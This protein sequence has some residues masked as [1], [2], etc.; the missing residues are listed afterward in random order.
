[1]ASCSEDQNCYNIVINII[2]QPIFLGYVPGIGN[3][4]SVCQRFRMARPLT[5][6]QLQFSKNLSDLLENRG[7]GLLEQSDFSSCD[8]GNLE[9]IHRLKVNSRI[10]SSPE[11]IP[12][13][14]FR[15]S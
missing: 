11:E 1:M 2:H 14:S 6:M 3:V 10:D 8:F 4:V 5:R 13:K 15:L 12:E 9:S 7:I